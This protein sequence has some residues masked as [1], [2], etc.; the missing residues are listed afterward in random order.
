MRK[1]DLIRC[2]IIGFTEGK[3]V[4]DNENNPN[5]TESEPIELPI[6]TPESQSAWEF[7]YQVGTNGMKLNESDM[8]N[9]LSDILWDSGSELELKD[10]E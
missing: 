4:F 8:D 7:G 6:N 2:I 5:Y 10:L 1:V 3:E 9:Y